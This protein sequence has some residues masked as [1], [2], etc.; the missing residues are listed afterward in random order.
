M[1]FLPIAKENK[2]DN[3][4]S[5]A[6]NLSFTR[7][8]VVFILDIFDPY[9]TIGIDIISCGMLFI[10]ANSYKTAD[11][12][13]RYCVRNN[14]QDVKDEKKSKIEN[15]SEDENETKEE[16]IIVP[17]NIDDPSNDRIIK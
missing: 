5:F 11:R 3:Y 16:K 9:M 8:F 10:L 1:Q 7:L 17:L 12:W 6:Y 14:I 2:P 13:Y 4:L 15:K